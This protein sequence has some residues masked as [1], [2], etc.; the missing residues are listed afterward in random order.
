MKFFSILALLSISHICAHN[1][2]TE[3]KKV[4]SEDY[5]Q[6]I[7]RDKDGVEFETRFAEGKSVPPDNGG[8][9]G[10]LIYKYRENKDTLLLREVVITEA[11]SSYEQDIRWTVSISGGRVTSVRVLNFGRSRAYCLRI[12]VAA[13]DV[14]I[15]LR[16]PPLGDPRVMIEVYGY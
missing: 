12:D 2:T 6:E 10:D 16:I 4:P 8:N 14:Q 13:G 11:L 7:T 1:I 9:Y 5:L 15:F 3:L